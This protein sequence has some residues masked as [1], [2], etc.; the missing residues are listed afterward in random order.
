MEGGWFCDSC[1]L[2]LSLLWWCEQVVGVVAA[3]TSLVAVTEA[4]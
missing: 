2:E 3:G 4:L 1:Y